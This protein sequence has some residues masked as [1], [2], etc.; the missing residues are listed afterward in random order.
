MT[1]LT[2]RMALLGTA[3]L[4]AAPARAADWPTRT[5]RVIVPYPPG[6]STEITARIIGDKLGTAFGQ[7]FLIDNRP[8]A[9]GNLGM[10]MAAHTKPDGYTLAVATTAHAI[11]MTLFTGMTYD[12]MKSFAPIALLT[13]NPLVLVVTS[14]LPVKTIAELIA[15]AKQKPGELHYASSGNGQSTH[16]AAELFCSMAGI[17]MVHVPYKGSAPPSRT[18]WPAYAT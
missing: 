3:G 9:G 13:E 8:G 15:L 6:G 18:S 4:I 16:L 5:V 14:G 7:K 1:A 17:K 10:D 11:N 2:R 12:T